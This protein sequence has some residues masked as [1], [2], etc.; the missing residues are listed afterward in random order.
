MLLETLSARIQMFQTKIEDFERLPGGN[1]DIQTFP[2]VLHWVLTCGNY[3]P[4]IT[5]CINSVVVIGLQIPQ[6]ITLLV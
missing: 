6:Q 2:D 5:V 1:L 3:T 4:R